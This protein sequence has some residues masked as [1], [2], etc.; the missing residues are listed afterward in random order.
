[1]AGGNS[2]AENIKAT[3]E[4]LSRFAAALV[5]WNVEDEE[6]EPV[7]PTLDSIFAEDLGFVL[8]VIKAWMDAIAGVSGPLAPSLPAGEPSPEASIPME[9]LS[10]SQAS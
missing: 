5:S 6:G 4:L 9:S 8:A 3:R 1:V 2:V 10:L 7:P